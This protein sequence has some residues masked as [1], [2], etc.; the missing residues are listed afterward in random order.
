MRGGERKGQH[1]S[2]AG[3]CVRAQTESPQRSED[4]QA[5]TDPD[6]W[7]KKGRNTWF[8]VTPKRLKTNAFFT[9]LKA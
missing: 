5:K 8:R 1:T 3:V 9:V 7:I 2:A 6:N 4:L